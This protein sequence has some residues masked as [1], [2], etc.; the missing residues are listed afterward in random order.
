[1]EE[2]YG[3]NK[4]Y[5]DQSRETIERDIKLEQEEQARDAALQ[6]QQIADGMKAGPPNPDGPEP[7]GKNP[8][9]PQTPDQAQ[10]Q[11]EIDHAN[12]DP[13]DFTGLESTQE[14]G[15]AIRGGFIG[16]MSSIAT[17]PERM[18]D[19]MAGEDVGGPN[20][21]PD[22]DP[23][24]EKDR[25]LVRTWWGGL[26]QEAVKGLTIIAGGAFALRGLAKVNVPGAAKAITPA[27]TTKGLVGRTL[28][29]AAFEGAVD[30]ASQGDNV[31][32]MITEKLPWTKSFLGPLAV[33][34]K[35]HP[36]L[37]TFKNTVEIM[38]LAGL[39]DF[40][41]VKAGGSPEAIARRQSVE[42]QTRDK[43]RQEYMDQMR[44]DAGVVPNDEV[45]DIVPR[46]HLHKPVMDDWQGSPMSGTGKAYDVLNQK[47]RIRTEPGMKDGSTD[48]WTTPKQAENMANYSDALPKHIKETA[49]NLLGDERYQ[50]LK[51][52]IPGRDREQILREAV[53]S[54]Q[55][56]FG[57]DTAGMDPEEF[58]QTIRKTVINVGTENEFKAF[59]FD[60]VIAVDMINAELF[61]Q[62]RDLARASREIL[63]VADI[64]DVDGPMKTIYDRFIVGMTNVKATRRIW[65]LAGQSMG[66][67]VK[68][69]KA[70]VKK[71]YKEVHAESQFAAELMIDLIQRDTSD[72][73]VRAFVEL[74]SGSNK[75]QNWRDLDKYMRTKLRGMNLDGEG[76]GLLF[77]ELT[78][79]YTNSV[80]TSPKTPLRAIQGTA[81]A[82]FI[83]PMQQ[84]IGAA[85]TALLGNKASMEAF[86][87]SLATLNAMRQTIPEATRLFLEKSKA[88][89]T[90]D[91][92]SIRTRFSEYT[93]ADETWDMLGHHIETRGSLGDKAA[94]SLANI[95][96]GINDSS[97]FTYSTK[98]MS[99]TD[100]AFKTIMA[101]SRARERAFRKALAEGKGNS[102]AIVRK[103]EDEFFKEY[104]DVDGDLN[105]DSDAFLE[106]ITKEATL[107]TDLSGWGK[108]LDQLFDTMPF[109]KPFYLFARTGINGLNFSYKQLPGLGV[110][111]RQSIDI[112]RASADDLSLVAKYGIENAADLENAKALLA[113]RQAVGGAVTFMAA[114]HYMN[115]NLTGNGPR[116]N[117]L[118]AQ[119]MS[120][121]WKPR[122][123]KIGNAWVSY[124]QFEPFAMILSVVADIGDNQK[125]MGEQWANQNLATT[126]FAIG[127]G[128]IKKSYL[129]GLEDLL[130]LFD[131]DGKGADRIVGNFLNS[132]LPWASIR[133]DIGKVLNP[134][135]KEINADLWDTV[136]NR[137]LYME[138]FTTDPLPTKYDTLNAKPLRDWNFLERMVNAGSPIALSVADEGPGRQLLWDSGYD[139]GQ[140]TYSYRGVDLQDAPNVRSMF[141]QAIGNAKIT[142]GGVTYKNPEAAL[143]AIAKRPNVQASMKAMEDDRNNGRRHFDPVKV[144]VH[145]DLIKEIFTQARDSAWRQ[146]QSRPEVQALI[147]D[148]QNKDAEAW[149]RKHGLQQQTLQVTPFNMQNK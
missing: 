112:M 63:D 71:I 5:F 59:S 29:A 20:Y 62:L 13:K 107:T 136:R 117:R 38:G 54:V 64:T 108:S 78:G 89:L 61:T 134:Y 47:R 124:D 73:T 58:F 70:Q 67:K 16:G 76:Q 122:H 109:V 88:N 147:T 49:K 3:I 104:V 43:A 116:D 111:H 30:E 17:A 35:D 135:M 143:D 66:G 60:D 105:L 52:E 120:T 101:R 34:D 131:A 72:G 119:W 113:G 96:R 121:G 69:S 7:S 50:Q 91:V 74:F 45:T 114:Q 84:I 48:S 92:A 6:E 65:G 132:S 129:A 77:R 141:Q 36:L 24:P 137:N 102:K 115:G 95:A 86:R 56:T 145:N 148:K 9:E 127:A 138:H 25:P 46:G 106:S 15:N 27:T 128:A 51:K 41:T 149:N 57:R 31:S 110:L 98:I 146:I 2:Y 142:L 133:N 44:T 55:E 126:A 139:L 144:Y 125:L 22:W 39:A 81:T 40:V 93:K 85:P 75:I 94:Y 14:L 130:D 1:M 33:Q 100:D 97:F 12:K 8:E 11:R 10:K 99:A 37:K 28:G 19:M 83:R 140:T 87:G 80:L 4:D 90:G 53:E 103:Y 42:R 32:T 26:A 68:M 123:I 18:R 79:V 21:K 23:F 82:T 118:R